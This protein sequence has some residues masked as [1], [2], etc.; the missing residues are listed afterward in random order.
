MDS[1]AL[2]WP[3]DATGNATNMLHSLAH[4]VMRKQAGAML[5]PLEVEL[6]I[7]F[8]FINHPCFRRQISKTRHYINAVCCAVKIP[9]SELFPGS[10]AVLVLFFLSFHAVAPRLGDT[11]SRSL[12]WLIELGIRTRALWRGP[13]SWAAYQTIR[14]ARQPP[15]PQQNYLDAPPIA[16]PKTPPLLAP[17]TIPSFA[18]G[19]PV[20]INNQ[21]AAWP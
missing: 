17:H 16:P 9:R 7:C 1:H 4:V 10:G 13:S 14:G 2:V 20:E 11:N 6:P 12:A 15:P 18:V 19:T 3:L 8:P 5:L 21:R